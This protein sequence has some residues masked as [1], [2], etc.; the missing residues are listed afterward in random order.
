MMMIG[1]SS[2]EERLA[3]FL[4]MFSAR[5]APSERQRPRPRHAAAGYRR[6]SRP[7]DR[8]REPHFHAFQGPR[9]HELPRKR[10]VEIVRPDA[11]ARLAAADRD[12]RRPA[13]R[14]E[15]RLRRGDR[16]T[17]F[18]RTSRAPASRHARTAAIMRQMVTPERASARNS[19]GFRLRHFGRCGPSPGVLA[20]MRRWNGWTG[21]ASDALGASRSPAASRSNPS[22]T[23]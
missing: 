19:H 20:G 5:S 17:R 18:G 15:R 13:A 10:R 16:V 2:A 22:E 9:L 7:D 21:P 23:P 14:I 8:D 11:L 3:W 6:L 4:I 1:R 12:A